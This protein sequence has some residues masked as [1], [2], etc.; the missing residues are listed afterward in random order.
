MPASHPRSLFGGKESVLGR[1]RAAVSTND[2]RLEDAPPS[3]WTVDDIVPLGGSRVALTLNV[4]GDVVRA[5]AGVEPSFALHLQREGGAAERVVDLPS[6]EAGE[7]VLA[8]LDLVTPNGLAEAVGDWVLGVR[9]AGAPT[10]PLAAP[11]VPTQTCVVADNE[12]AYSVSLR[13]HGEGM[14]MLA[15]RRRAPHAEALRVRWESDGTT[16]TV[17]GVLPHTPDVPAG[18]A[19]LV[20]VRRQDGDVV[21]L[22]AHVDAGR[23]VVTLPVAELPATS[24]PASWDLSLALPQ[25]PAPLR[26]GAH[27][28]DVPGKRHKRS[29]AQH[30]LADADGAHTV[31][32]YWTKGDSL[33]IIVG[34]LGAKKPPKA[35]SDQPSTPAES[36][37]AG[38]AQPPVTS[39]GVA[40]A[41]PPAQPAVRKRVLAAVLR[42]LVPLILWPRAAPPAPGSGERPRVRFLLKTAYGMGGTI[43]TV[44]NI[45]GYLVRDH[46]VEIVS[47][48]RKRDE[49]FFPFPAGVTVRT[50]DDRRR[51]ARGKGAR[52]LLE[53]RLR[54]LPSVLVEPND[55]SYGETSL[56][57]DLHLARELRSDRGG[58]LVGTRPAYNL[59]AARAARPGLVAVGQEHMNFSAHRPGLRSAIED[60]YGGLDVLVTLT[61]EDERDYGRVLAD[62]RVRVVQIPNALPPMMGDVSP[63]TAPVVLAAGRLT[64][65]KGFDLLIDAF[66]L[67][68]PERPDWS[69]R[70][71]GAG[72]KQGKLTR[73]VQQRGLSDDVLLMGSSRHLGVEMSR[74]SVF[75]LSSRFEGFGM[76]IIEAMS[77]GLPVVSF[78]CPRGPAEIITHGHDGLLVPDGDVEAFAAALLRLTGDPE[79]RIRMASAARVTAARYDIDAVGRQWDVLLGELAGAHP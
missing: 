65:Q 72:P 37:S 38:A 2:R 78:D 74:A 4:P 75:A 58:V 52:G 76:V 62:G 50:L 19:E 13:A 54:A 36:G 68:A 70:I 34:V 39:P 45:A 56:W 55:V 73:Q 66:A 47:V 10:T 40:P 53:R 8:T 28:D 14:V 61:E 33:S 42:R 31:Q 63:L 64:R 57:T 49:P 35:T 12:A 16:V 69:V 11:T 48:F 30:V 9:R 7:G 17:E 60:Q 15:V 77:K 59:L 6:P 3:V 41:V 22:P 51:S 20:A 25:L 67:V 27:L 21:R 79:L 32:P 23:F 43:R 46:E 1:L 71:Y 5:Q 44:L 24:F 18:A 26:L 29:Y